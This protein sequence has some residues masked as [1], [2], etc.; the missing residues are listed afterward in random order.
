[1]K[2]VYYILAAITAV[3]VIFFAMLPRGHEIGY[4]EELDS[5][6]LYGDVRLMNDYDEVKIFESRHVP[7]ECYLYTKDRIISVAIDYLAPFRADGILS[8]NWDFA[9]DEVLTDKSFVTVSVD[10]LCRQSGVYRLDENIINPIFL[11]SL[12]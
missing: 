1:M 9:K 6:I 10:T 12:K 5:D 7:G 2:L 4:T 11:V 3:N 8:C